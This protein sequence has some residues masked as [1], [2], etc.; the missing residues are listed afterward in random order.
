MEVGN[1]KIKTVKC[2]ALNKIVKFSYAKLFRYT[3]VTILACAWN[4]SY[5]AIIYSTPIIH[6]VCTQI[7][8]IP[9]YKELQIAPL[10]CFML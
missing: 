8:Q 6:C 7:A 9:K 2:L 1:R 3:V 5:I 10:M 4:I